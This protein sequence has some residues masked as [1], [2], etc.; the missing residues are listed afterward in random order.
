MNATPQS[1][2]RFLYKMKI[3]IIAAIAKN[4]VIGA[5][6]KLLWHLQ[7]DLP[8]FKKITTGHCILMGQNTYESIGRVLPDRTNIILSYD[9]NYKVPGGFVFENPEDALKFSE[10]KGEKELMI[11]GGGMIYKYFLPLADK[12]YLTRILKDFDGDVTFPEINASEW[13][14]TA[15]EKHL[16]NDP[17]FEYAI[18]ERV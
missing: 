15:S 6:N 1:K 10:N 7:G 13:E 17:P 8:R 16:E 4:N 2:P 12:I 18:L 5:K 9:K 11:I 14:E 3:S